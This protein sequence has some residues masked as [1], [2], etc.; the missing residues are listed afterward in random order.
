MD[1]A[2]KIIYLREK[3]GYSTNKLAKLSCVSQSYLRDIEQGKSQPTVDVL[4][5]ICGVLDITISD[6]FDES[7]NKQTKSVNLEPLISE[8]QNLYST[9]V[10]LVKNIVTEFSKVN[11]LLK[12]ST[13]KT[14][15]RE[16][17]D[18]F[19]SKEPITLAGKPISLE[20]RIQIL[21]VLRDILPS[22]DVMTKEDNEVLAASYEGER[23]FHI[24]TLEE[25]EDI[26]KAI[27][28][29]MAQ[30]KKDQEK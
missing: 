13:T 10:D 12:R 5:R 24:P 28:A 8:I 27:E 6:F 29:A 16:I 3:K 11:Q 19:N 1:I 15:S 2:S 30:K 20:E 9:Q 26:Q 18:L 21:E 23:F 25:G 14:L 7:N 22:E 17:L 4:S